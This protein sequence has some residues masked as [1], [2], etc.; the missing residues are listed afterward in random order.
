MDRQMD[1]WTMFLLLTDAIDASENDGYPTALAVFT[2][3]LR[4][5]RPA[6]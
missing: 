2:K 4:T 3:A 5:K 6:D 1:G